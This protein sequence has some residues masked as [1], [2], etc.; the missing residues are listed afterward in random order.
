MLIW[1]SEAVQGV[2]AMANEGIEGFKKY[3]K[4]GRTTIPKVT[5]RKNKVLAFNSAAVSKFDLDAF[6]YAVF[7]ISED[8]KRIAIQFTN[9]E[10]ESGILGIQSRPGNFQIS[11][12]HFFAMND[13]DTSENRNYDFTWDTKTRVAFFKP[14][15]A[16]NKRVVRSK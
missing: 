11:A 3:I 6:K 5:V 16:V 2:H 7:Y 1:A 12:G 15:I 10:N 14:D 8:G 9:N 13:I 4:R